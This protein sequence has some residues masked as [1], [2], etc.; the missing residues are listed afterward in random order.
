MDDRFDF[1]LVS[2]PVYYGS[3]KVS[4]V[5]NSYHALGNDGN[6]FNKSINSPANQDVPSTIAN[7]LYNMS[8][9]LPVI[10]DLAVDLTPVS[11]TSLADFDVHVVNPVQNKLQINILPS[12]EEDLLIELYSMEGKLLQRTQQK[13]TNDGIRLEYDFPYVSGFY[14][15][16]LT[17]SHQ[18]TVVK[19]IVK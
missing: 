8:D 15:L 3:R 14:I 2:S 12:N 19:K 11:V 18:S 9:H 5:D 7:A 6:H 13:V 10:L 16:K 17:D 1:I 4:Y